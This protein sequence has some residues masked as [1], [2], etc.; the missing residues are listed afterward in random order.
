MARMLSDIDMLT[1][2]TS[3]EIAVA[4]NR[5]NTVRQIE[6][7]SK[8]WRNNF[9][10]MSKESLCDKA[11]QLTSENIQDMN[12]DPNDIDGATWFLGIY[13]RVILK[14]GLINATFHDIM[15]N[16]MMRYFN[17]L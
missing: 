1:Y 3:A 13:T 8:V 11:V 14:S 17:G 10:G 12:W 6:E 5:P 9:V 7:L 15:S 2:C 16:C 4:Y